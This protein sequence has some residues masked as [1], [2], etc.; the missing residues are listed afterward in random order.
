MFVRETLDGE[1]ALYRLIARDG[2]YLIAKPDDDRPLVEQVAGYTESSARKVVER[3]EHIECWNTTAELSNPSTSIGPNEVQVEILVDG[4]A[5]SGQE[6]RLEYQKGQGGDW[7]N[8]E[9]TIRLTNTGQRT[10]FVGLLDLPQTFGIFPMLLNVGSQKL[11]PGEVGFANGG[12]PIAVTVPDDLWQRGMN[13]ITDIVKVIVST[14]EF[15]V[16]RMSQDDLDVPRPADRSAALGAMGVT[17]GL[18]QPGT[19][20][21]LMERVQTRHAGPGATARVDDWRSLQFTFATVRPLPAGRLEPGRSASLTDG[22]R[23]EPHPSLRVDSARL[24]S[25]PVASRALEGLAPLPR[26]LYDDPSVVQPFEFA[27]TRSVGGVLNVLELS[28]VNDP[29][30]VTPENPLQVTIPRSLSPG[31]Y[32]L[33][34]AFDGEFYLPL[35][36]AQGVN[37]ETLVTLDRLPQPSEAETRSLGGS[38]RILFQKVLAR[39]FGTKYHYPILAAAKVN[40]DFSVVYDPDPASVCARVAKANRIALFVHGIIGDT[41]EMSA[42]LSRAGAANHYD[43]VLTFDYENLQDPISATAL[44]LKERLKAAGLGQEGHGKMLDVFAHSMGGLVSRWFIEREGGNKVVRRLVM[45][46][47]PNGGS[48][49]P[50]VVDWATTAIAVGMNELS[51]VAWPAAILGGLAQAASYAEVTLEQMMPDSLFLKDLLASPDP[52]VP[53]LLIAG[54][55]SRIVSNPQRAS[56]LKKLLMRLW[57]DRSKYDLADRFFKGSENDIAVSL[58]SMQN[59]AGGR[60]PALEVRTVPCDHLT[61]FRNPASLSAINQAARGSA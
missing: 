7:L 58:A 37:G 60:N 33:P 12:E 57:S 45:L 38:L 46:G 14:S 41:R 5:R 31:E 56:K 39:T 59:L 6:L 52:G 53:Y 43:L 25:L 32:V 27:P 15:D 26:L 44:G 36:R 8:P 22:V 42:S 54:E 23:I 55:T 10:M 29:A 51:P 4:Q 24:S 19:L 49:W 16:R 11:A 18:G 1:E 17:R 20:D 28:G 21:R 47:T 34:V 2:Q 48:P 30:L 40:D 50:N 13:E 3:L 9:I 35:G 61:Y